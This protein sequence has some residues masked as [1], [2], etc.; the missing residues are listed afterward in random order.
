MQHFLLI[1]L[2]T[3]LV[4]FSIGYKSDYQY[5]LPG[6]PPHFHAGRIPPGLFEYPKHNGWMK[7]GKAVKICET[8]L[9]CG[10]FTFKGTPNF[11]RK[12]EV[13]FFH[14]VP[15]EI[16]LEGKDTKSDKKNVSGQKKKYYH[17]SSYIVHS[18][19]FVKL[20]VHVKDDSKLK[21]SLCADAQTRFD[22]LTQSESQIFNID[23]SIVAI[24][25]DTSKC[26][27]STIF[28]N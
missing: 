17:W 3:T 1:L 6:K 14:F 5:E 27:S 18:R 26:L 21:T 7:P 22:K 28:L 16:F 4:P 2:L 13:Y 12:H 23:Q 11:K 15:P 25:I 24:L 20:S 9:A 10:G 19:D 8:D